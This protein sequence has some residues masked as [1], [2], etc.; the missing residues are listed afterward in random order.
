MAERDEAREGDWDDLSPEAARRLWDEM[1]ARASDQERIC[2]NCVN[3]VWPARLEGDEEMIPWRVRYP[4]CACHA[5]SPG[6]PREV[7]P[8]GSCPRF[9][10]KTREPVRGEPP[11]PRA[12]D[13]QVHSADPGVV[14]RRRCCGLRAAEQ[15]PL[16]RLAQR[17][18]E[19]VCPA[20]YQD[21]HHPDAPRDH[22]HAAGNGGG[23]QGPGRP[24]QPPGKPPQLHAGAERVQQGAPRAK[25]AVQGRVS[26]RRQVVRDDPAQGHRL[27]PGHRS[28]TRSRPPRPATAR[29]TNS[30]A[31][32]RTSTSP[33]RFGHSSRHDENRRRRTENRRLELRGLMP[34]AA[35]Q[36]P[37]MGHRR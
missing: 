4:V 23:P 28:T 26:A 20:E 22:A 35:L 1:Q 14:G 21:Q 6:V 3:M 34:L 5:D 18:R 31:S 37:Q 11:E 13:G 19:D 24:E 7:H 15:V 16:V 30:K 29:R 25:V 27:L 8:C 2:L 36:T 10:A 9:R 33:R 32:T 12:A 17:R